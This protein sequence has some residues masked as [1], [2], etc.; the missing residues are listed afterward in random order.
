MD[1]ASAS[2]T[3]LTLYE[4]AAPYLTAG[5]EVAVRPKATLESLFGS[6]AE[7]GLSGGTSAGSS[8]EVLRFDSGPDAFSR[9]YFNTTAN[10]WRKPSDAIQD[11]GHAPFYADEGLTLLRKATLPLSFFLIGDVP[12]DPALRAAAVDGPEV[13]PSLSTNFKSWL[14]AN[15]IP[16]SSGLEG[17]PDGDG[18]NNLYEY[19]FGTDPKSSASGVA[20]L[21]YSG[22]LSGGGTLVAKGSPIT[23]VEVIGTTVTGMIFVRLNPLL[24]SDI[25]YIPQFS[26]NGATWV[27]STAT[28][29][30]LATDGDYQAVSIPYPSFTGGKKTRF[31]RVVVTPN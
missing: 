14:I 19:A 15:N 12:I 29:S 30:I 20:G 27:T 16:L 5:T 17:N 2:S 23:K 26:N 21:E 28:P 11:E 13:G 18:L 4:D 7:S 8:D 24:S 3:A 9:F 31:Y 10:G 25:S 22:S 6:D 1:V